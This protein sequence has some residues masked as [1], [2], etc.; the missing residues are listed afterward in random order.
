MPSPLH[1]LFRLSLVACFCGGAQAGLEITGPSVLEPAIVGERRLLGQSMAVD[2]DQMLIGA[3]R[4][5]DNHHIQVLTRSG[6]DWAFTGKLPRP[7]SNPAY[8]DATFGDYLAL[9]GYYAAVSATGVV[10]NQQTGAGLVHLY[11]KT[12]NGWE[13]DRPLESPDPIGYAGFGAILRMKGDLMF[14]GESGTGKVHC[15]ERTGAAWNLQQTLVIPASKAPKTSS[16]RARLHS[17]AFDSNVLA[18]GVGG[19][20][21]K[22]HRGLVYLYELKNNRWVK[23]T[24]L[25]SIH[26]NTSFGSS[27]ALNQ[28]RLAVF[29]SWSTGQ[30]SIQVFAKTAQ[31][32]T[33]EG[34]IVGEHQF[35]YGAKLAL[36]GNML[37]WTSNVAQGIHVAARS[38][39]NWDLIKSLESDPSQPAWRLFGQLAFSGERLLA[40]MPYHYERQIPPRYVDWDGALYIFE[41]QTTPA[42]HLH[43][44]DSLIAPRL[45]SNDGSA[46]GQVASGQSGRRTFTLHNRGHA[47]L[48]GLS[49]SVTGDGFSLAS[50]PPTI[51]EPGGTFACD[52]VFQPQALGVIEGLLQ[53]ASNDP[54]HPLFEV[55]LTGE[56]LE[57][58]TPPAVHTISPA[59]IVQK[60]QDVHFVVDARG[61]EPLRYQ[62]KHNGKSIPGATDRTFFLPSAT[63]NK[64]G[65]YTVEISNDSGRIQSIPAPLGVV[66]TWQDERMIW[67]GRTF[68]IQV[69][70]S[71]P[72]LALQ[73]HKDNVPLFNQEGKRTGVTKSKLVVSNASEHDAGQYT[74]S[75]TLGSAHL[76]T[77]GLSDISLELRPRFLPMSAQTWRVGFPVALAVQL[78]DYESSHRPWKLSPL[79]PGIK[80]RTP[81]AYHNWALHFGGT[82][83]KAGKY[84]IQVRAS[85]WVGTSIP[86]RVPVTVLPLGEVGGQFTGCVEPLPQ[87][88]DLGGA[89]DFTVAKTGVISG[90][91]LLGGQK[92]SFRHQGVWNVDPVLNP[93][94]TFGGEIPLPDTGDWKLVLGINPQT[95]IA[96]GEIR[97]S[98]GSLTSAVKAVRLVWPDP[99]NP[100]PGQGGYTVA[101]SPMSG[102]DPLGASFGRMTLN[103]KGRVRWTGKAGDG[104][105]L[106]RSSALGT[107]LSIPLSWPLYSGRGSLQTWL[108]IDPAGI[109]E[110][111]GTA[112][113]TKQSA[114][115][116][117]RSYPQ[118]FA[119]TNLTV[120]G[121]RYQAPA[122][123]HLVLNAP[124]SPGT[125][126]LAVVF[127]LDRAS[128]GA[129]TFDST[130]QLRAT[131]RTHTITAG[132]N[133]LSVTLNPATGMLHG[134]WHEGSRRGTFAGVMLP[135][136][137]KAAGHALLPAST[138]PAKS[139]TIISGSLSLEP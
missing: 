64:S 85:N 132:S 10:A 23:T 133:R 108:Q 73:W 103:R 71:G 92:V 62:W 9:S 96:T 17:V 126:E 46:L 26:S 5:A 69:E 27:I 47:N 124:H 84:E 59:Q 8:P 78:V 100:P 128:Q 82:P 121:A 129:A 25:T 61:A 28:N 7:P 119:K 72:D 111:S 117:P 41:Y 74:F 107:D 35:G 57:A 24:T 36:Q 94:A 83:T 30:E 20:Y 54:D 2:G 109:D 113:W 32:W 48:T 104:T 67:E 123:G 39:T 56:G 34:S 118:G 81:Y 87:L 86:L 29:G 138:I 22:G 42:L 4:A 6:S 91:I 45:N 95:C 18:I 88:S 110:V 44:G 90:K 58:P 97:N 136:L 130:F 115:Q 50:A 106:T 37:A 68:S 1:F 89:L 139:A 77:V 99:A 66:C 79:P 105:V 38:G 112:F 65:N 13:Y 53:I 101:L 125:A 80:L 21:S 120:A 93:N 134:H 19:D 127:D 51:L 76:P 131:S 116:P 15:Y 40:G 33:R 98:S 43:D 63:L 102:S 11:V 31:G 114:A 135:H 12:G 70:A 3:S 14:V 16:G 49:A 60:D 55:L 122:P 52:V 75:A 137:Q